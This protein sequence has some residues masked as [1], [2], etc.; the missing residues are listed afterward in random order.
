MM[1]KE[2]RGEEKNISRKNGKWWVTNK[3]RNVRREKEQEYEEDKG[4]KE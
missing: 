3:Y 2:R 1:G 4:D